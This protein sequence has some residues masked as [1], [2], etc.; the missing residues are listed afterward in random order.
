[1]NWVCPLPGDWSSLMRLFF[2]RGWSLR[3][4]ESKNPWPPFLSSAPD[5]FRDLQNSGS[6]TLGK[7]VVLIAVENWGFCVSWVVWLMMCEAGKAAFGEALRCGGGGSKF[8]STTKLSGLNREPAGGFG[9]IV[10]ESPRK[11]PDEIWQIRTQGTLQKSYPQ[12]LGNYSRRLLVI[13][14]GSGECF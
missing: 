13:L 10:F 1:M 9:S 12:T 3:D 7:V 14:T 8:K 2:C 6:A 4:R 5:S 11:P